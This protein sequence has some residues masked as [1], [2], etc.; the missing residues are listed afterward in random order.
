M[1][2]KAHKAVKG[3]EQEIACA[4]AYLAA[5]IK[6]NKTIAILM[7]L[8]PDGDALGSC[9]ALRRLC[10][11]LGREAKVYCADPVPKKYTFLPDWEKIQVVKKAPE[12]EV[13]FC[14]L[15]DVP[16]V[17]R[18]GSAYKIYEKA[19]FSL[20]LDHHGTNP[21]YAKINVVDAGCAAAGELV[22]HLFEALQVPLDQE[23]ATD[24]YVALSTDTG[25]FQ[26]PST[27]PDTL[28]CAAKTLESGA[29]AEKIIFALYRTRSL[30]HTRLLGCALKSLQ[31]FK[32]NKV[33]MLS[34]TQE[35]FSSCEATEEDAEGIVNYAV[36]IKGV[37]LALLAT[38]NK[39]VWKVSLRAK[40]GYDVSGVAQAFSGGGHRLAAGCTL[41]HAQDKEKL[42][43]AL[44]AL[45]DE[46]E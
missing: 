22:L 36:E 29:D 35:D 27:T 4:G 20:S 46:E 45:L 3:V 28:R 12:E 13:D 43:E 39:Q 11:A 30:A 33:A 14:L 26:F 32:E 7:H 5:A 41:H 8:S 18:L 16:D 31:L 1:E 24:L 9:L 6:E 2:A 42:L 40:E 37:C 19:A 17:S 38:Q 10:L 15:C 21:R 34:L 25:H 44:C 23:S